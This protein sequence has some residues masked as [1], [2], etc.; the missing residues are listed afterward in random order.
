MG[1]VDGGM[2]L[3]PTETGSPEITSF[4]LLTGEDLKVLSR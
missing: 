2:Y 3:T 1:P 4:T